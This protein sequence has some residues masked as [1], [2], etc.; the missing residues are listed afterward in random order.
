MEYNNISQELQTLCFNASIGHGT[1]DD[2]HQWLLFNKTNPDI[3]SSGIVLEILIRCKAPLYV[4]ETYINILWGA[5]KMIFHLGQHFLHIACSVSTSFEVFKRLFENNYCGI[6][7]KDNNGNLPLH[8]ACM[9][10]MDI[11][12]EII[13]IL[14]WSA[15]E[16]C[17]SFN[18]DGFSPKDLLSNVA[19]NKDETGM[20]LL[21]HIA[22][23]KYVTA[24]VI[25]FVVDAYPNGIFTPDN[26]GM[27]PFHHYLLYSWIWDIDVVYTLLQL[28]PD[29]VA[30]K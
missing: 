17:Y 11:S 21:H 14:V 22:R 10:G 26:N 19:M 16:T 8:H 25:E 1:Y 15:D 9:K 3:V 6:Y 27:L 12:P 29:A 24:K 5:G 13:S 4:V 23:S 18:N 2:I 20:T 30:N 7:T 28:Y